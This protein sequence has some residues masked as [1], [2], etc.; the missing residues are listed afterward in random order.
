MDLVLHLTS[1]Y[2]VYCRS[3][4]SMYVLHVSP[5]K[6]IL[7]NI[8]K[9]GSEKKTLGDLFLLLFISSSFRL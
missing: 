5:T 2:T 6:V 7:K 4:I 9:S 8:Y 3:A 1:V